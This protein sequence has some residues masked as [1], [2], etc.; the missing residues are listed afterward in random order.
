MG[1]VGNR[2]IGGFE[3]F[4]GLHG[5]LRYLAGTCQLRAAAPVAVAAKSIN[6]RQNPA[7]Y[8]EIGLLT[9]LAKQVQTHRHAV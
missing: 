8:H 7:C 9:R 5:Q 1:Q 6:V 2:R 3:E 4:V